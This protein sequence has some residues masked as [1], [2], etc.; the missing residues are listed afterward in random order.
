MKQDFGKKSTYLEK[1]WF[2][3]EKIY[4]LDIAAAVSIVAQNCLLKFAE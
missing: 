3:G 4:I 2:L 1:M